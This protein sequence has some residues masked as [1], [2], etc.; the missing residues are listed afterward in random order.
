MAA[1]WSRMVRRDYGATIEP[2][3]RWQA[4][5]RIVSFRGRNWRRIRWLS[6][7]SGS[8]QYPYAGWRTSGGRVRHCS[9]FKLLH[10]IPAG[11]YQIAGSHLPPWSVTVRS[12]RP[13][14]KHATSLLILFMLAALS[15]CHVPLQPYRLGQSAIVVPPE[16]NPP[17]VAKAPSKAE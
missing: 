11:D 5:S 17:Q 15:G 12:W 9:A 7:V 14:M 4:H 13:T 10:R 8:R 2:Q 3:W 16:T 1:F 6:V